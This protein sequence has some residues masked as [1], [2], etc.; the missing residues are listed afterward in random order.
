[1]NLCVPLIDQ[2]TQPRVYGE[3]KKSKAPPA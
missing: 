2:F 1:M 3:A